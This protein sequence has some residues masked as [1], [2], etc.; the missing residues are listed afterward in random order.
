MS[1]TKGNWIFRSDGYDNY[2]I[3]LDDIS[4]KNSYIGEIGGGMQHDYEVKANARLIAS[5]PELLD[6]CKK[7]L[8]L[9]HIWMPPD[10]KDKEFREESMAL[11]SMMKKLEFAIKRAEL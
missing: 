9:K 11:G 10:T 5:S 4:N 8:S 6:A 2:Y 7:V 3:E 1:Y